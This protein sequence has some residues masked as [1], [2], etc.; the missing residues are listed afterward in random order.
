M[1][2]VK[3]PSLVL[4]PSTFTVYRR[5]NLAH[6]EREF[7]DVMR[8]VGC[9]W[10]KWRRRKVNVEISEYF[11]IFST[12]YRNIF[13]SDMSQSVNINVENFFVYKLTICIKWN[14]S[15]NISAYLKKNEATR[16]MKS[17]QNSKVKIVKCDKY[18][19]FMLI[20]VNCVCLLYLYCLN[21]HVKVPVLLNK[22]TRTRQQRSHHVLINRSQ[23]IESE[24]QPEHT[25]SNQH[26]GDQG[27]LKF[28][29]TQTKNITVKEAVQ[30]LL[31]RKWK[32]NISVILQLWV[33][34]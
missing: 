9:A 19:M 17:E 8:S 27:N 33:L 11:C 23:K 22:R 14:Y 24:Q 13:Q 5:L 3:N 6:L 18:C 31:L 26:E 1:K 10:A 25:P 29:F 32:F 2:I 12:L 4:L 21:Q 16:K 20:F 7:H 34:L 28:H 30:M 15:Y